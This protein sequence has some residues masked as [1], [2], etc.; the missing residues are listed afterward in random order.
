MVSQRES[1]IIAP[2][3]ILI[4]NG[5]LLPEPLELE[6]DSVATGWASVAN[7]LSGHELEKGL[8]TA[9]FG[10]SFTWPVRS[11][12]MPLVLRGKRW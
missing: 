9:G 11:G 4:K 8:A 3:A 1:R 5:T 12:R 2:G 7:N 10:R 6:N